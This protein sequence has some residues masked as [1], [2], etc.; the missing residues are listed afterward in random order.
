MTLQRLHV[1]C[2]RT[3]QKRTHQFVFSDIVTA[4][5]SVC[6][7]TVQ[8][9][10][11]VLLRGMLTFTTLAFYRAVRE[12]HSSLQR[13]CDV[14]WHR[15]KVP[16]WW[17]RQHAQRHVPPLRHAHWLV[18]RLQGRPICRLRWFPVYEGCMMK[19]VKLYLLPLHPQCTMKAVEMYLLPR[20]IQPTNTSPYPTAPGFAQL[21]C[22][23]E[24]TC[25]AKRLPIATMPQSKSYVVEVPIYPLFFIATITHSKAFLLWAQMKQKPRRLQYEVG[26]LSLWF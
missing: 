15:S 26:Q 23:W 14:H 16:S 1:L 12:L 7:R 6:F 3:V 22:P 4:T 25:V 21:C 13:H 18:W 20:P 8:K 10:R 9:L 19:A 24:E 5:S 11:T 2:F 17:H